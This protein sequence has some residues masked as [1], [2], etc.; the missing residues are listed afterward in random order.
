M[1][2][3]AAVAAAKEFEQS[4]KK[5]EPAVTSKPVPLGAVCVWRTRTGGETDSEQAP[6]LELTVERARAILADA[7]RAKI[8]IL[9]RRRKGIPEMIQ[10]LR[11]VGIP[12]SDEGGNPLTDSVAVLHALSLLHLADHPGDLAAAFHVATSPLGARV[13]LSGD[14]FRKTEIAR[15]RAATVAR[16]VRK[17]LAEKGYGGWLASIRPKE[18]G[19]DR[20]ASEGYGAWDTERFSQLIDLALAWEPRAGSRPRAFVEHVR[21]TK[22]EDPSAEQVRV[23]TVHGAK[24]LEFDA[25]ILP[26]L[27]GRLA[28]REDRLLTRRPDPEGEIE[29]VTHGLRKEVSVAHSE[30]EAVRA[31]VARRRMMEEL[32]VLYVA[33]TRAKH[34][35]DLIVQGRE[36]EGGGLTDAAILGSAL[37]FDAVGSE[38]VVWNSEENTEPWFRNEIGPFEE[39]TAQSKAAAQGAAASKKGD[40]ASSERVSAAASVQ[41]LGMRGDL[42]GTTRGR[43]RLAPSTKARS[44]PGLSP[45][46][47]KDVG[48]VRAS[49]L[50][51]PHDAMT[52]RGRLIHRFLEEVEWIETFD[53]SDEELT[54][55]GRRIEADEG[56]VASALAEFRAALGRPVT[57][58]VLSR[59]EGDVEV[60]RERRFALVMTDGEGRESLWSGA[61]DR[62]VIE[63][64]G[65]RAVSAQ[66]IDYKT[67]RV[68]AHELVQRGKSYEQQMKAYERAGAL[69]TGVDPSGI[70]TRILFLSRDAISL[71]TSSGNRNVSV[72]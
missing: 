48:P 41:S 15:E 3:D 12:A 22:V 6:A 70:T 44:L 38:F 45:S 2:R 4:F 21:K 53:R 27:D 26:E 65:G 28:Q 43:L 52:A 37:G 35:L 31:D 68:E 20:E 61:F 7:P 11:D 29:V 63:R 40:A 30:L 36:R 16:D 55:I 1:P 59:P 10:R 8:G 39:S 57:K 51:R 9:T 18:S 54:A 49:E 60:W 69:I 19:G 50:L 72:S 42:P 14:E 24:G 17:A 47:A 46:H 71:G 62:V 56:V 34:R 58:G 66:I 13:G 64:E 5:H 23:M 67:D 25:V 33:M 32:C